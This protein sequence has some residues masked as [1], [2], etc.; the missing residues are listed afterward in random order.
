M[1]LEMTILCFSNCLIEDT[2]SHQI[3]H[4]ILFV[5]LEV[6]TIGPQTL[7]GIEV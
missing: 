2:I 4:S 1:K 7:Q 3:Q 5:E 6:P